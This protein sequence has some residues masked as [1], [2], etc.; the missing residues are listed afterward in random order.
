MFPGAADDLLL[1]TDEP[2]SAFLRSLPG[3]DQVQAFENTR[4][5]DPPTRRWRPR[6]TGAGLLEDLTRP[7]LPS[8]TTTRV[9]GGPGRA[10]F[11]PDPFPVLG[12][13]VGLIVGLDLRPPTPVN[14]AGGGPGFF[15][16]SS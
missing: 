4:L 5:R 12:I 8:S 11:S 9:Q 14:S 6:V 3:P 7:S 10:V 2:L 1:L 16:R 15:R 13:M